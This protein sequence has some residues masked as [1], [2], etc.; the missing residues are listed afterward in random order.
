[1]V[2]VGLLAVTSV[3]VASSQVTA[4]VNRRVTATAAL[5]GVFVGQQTTGLEAPVHSYATRP[6]VVA[7][8][9]AGPAAG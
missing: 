4:E 9:T 1:M 6:T 8:I 3:A 5:S 7:D 2:A